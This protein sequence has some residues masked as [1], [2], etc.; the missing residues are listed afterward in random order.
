MH[1]CDRCDKT[2]KRKY[3]LERHL[4]RKNPCQRPG[5]KTYLEKTYVCKGCDRV[6]KSY[7]GKW[8][9]EKTCSSTHQILTEM[10]ERLSQYE[11]EKRQFIKEK[12]RMAKQIEKLMMSQK[13]INNNNTINIRINS[14]GS[15]STEHIT[16]NLLQR[17]LELT[18]FKAIPKLIEQ[19]HFHPEHPENCNVKITNH[20]EKFAKVFEDERWKLARKDEILKKMVDSGFTLMDTYYE[21]GGKQDISTTKRNSYEVFQ[22]KMDDEESETR[23]AVCQNAELIV[24]NQNK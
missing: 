23:K 8:K 24:L 12:K 2:F 1:R 4:K 20:R 6:Y 18:P 21:A 17:L 16:E 7:L 13:T 11:E 9:H 5:G 10:E 3:D 19:I 14:F 15:E 22:G